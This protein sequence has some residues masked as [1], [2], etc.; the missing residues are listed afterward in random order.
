MKS[1]NSKSIRPPNLAIVSEAIVCLLF[2]IAIILA[3]RDWVVWLTGIVIL[4][5][6]GFL[7]YGGLVLD[8]KIQKK[9]SF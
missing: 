2:G 4:A 3:I 9:S 8:R 6:A 7:L 1:N 5:L